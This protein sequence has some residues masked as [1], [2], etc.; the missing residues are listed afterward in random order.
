[1]T[2]ALIADFKKHITEE[3][4]LEVN[5]TIPFESISKFWQSVKR[6]PVIEMGKGCMKMMT[7]QHVNYVW[8]DRL[9]ETARV[10]VQS[11]LIEKHKFRSQDELI[12]VLALR[13]INRRP[14]THCLRFECDPIYHTL[15]LDFELQNGVIVSGLFIPTRVANGS[16]TLDAT[17]EMNCVSF[18]E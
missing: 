6:A 4:R 1:M 5:E 16:Q 14:D 15:A 7:M 9:F 10:W 2:P 11:A 18:D 12:Q 3:L 17:C 8:K 13:G